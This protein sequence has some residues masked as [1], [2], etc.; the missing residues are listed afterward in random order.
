M[1]GPMHSATVRA[2]MRTAQWSLD[3]SR[4]AHADAQAAFETA[5]HEWQKAGE[6]LEAAG[7][8][9]REVLNRQTF[10]IAGLQC[11]YS[12]QAF[13][14]G[15]LDE[16]SRLRTESCRRVEETRQQLKAA[17]SR[18]QLY[19]RLLE[20]RRQMHHRVDLQRSQRELDDL[21]VASLARGFP[22]LSNSST[23]ELDH[24][25]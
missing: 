13:M 11:A 25:A 19:E 21:G 22:M 18:L 24:G 20:R 4:A 23:Q 15:R 8:C 14:R 17:Q 2:L 6:G 9:I 3:D 10:D 5:E 16:K 12:H 7:H 1:N